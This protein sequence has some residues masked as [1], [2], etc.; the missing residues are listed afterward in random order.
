MEM[1]EDDVLRAF[2]IG[3]A[4]HCQSID[5]GLIN[6]TFLIEAAGRTLIL[7]RLN[8]QVFKNPAGIMSNIASVHEELCKSTSYVVPEICQSVDGKPYHIDAHGYAW[9][10][11][12]F[13]PNSKTI[14]TTHEPAIAKEAGRIIGLFH[15][16][17]ANISPSSLTTTL[18][19]FH[20]VSFRFEEF[21]QVVDRADQQL[22]ENASLP[23]QFVE[24]HVQQM[25]QLDEVEV[26]TR[27]TH[28]D[29]K[30]NNILF[31]RTSDRARCLIDLDTLMPGYIHHDFGDAIRTLCNSVSENEPDVS[32]VSFQWE[33]FESFCQGYFGETQQMLS[34]KEW[35]IFPQSI[36]LLPFLMGLR[37]LTDY[38]AG[39]VYYQTAYVDQN[40]DRAQNQFR[41]LAEIRNQAESIEQCIDS[42]KPHA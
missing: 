24:D 30:L 1:I 20:R 19:H 12:E 17:T 39:N 10:A 38:L 22:L 8:K 11:M 7:Q 2:Q 4:V 3:E 21:Q 37:F 35:T 14:D 25:M 6:K 40:L 28:N 33:L 34:S 31:D 16:L 27:V 5:T 18:P 41:L 9:R 42:F 36:E 32:T 15:R 29:T 23:I 13:I 26:P